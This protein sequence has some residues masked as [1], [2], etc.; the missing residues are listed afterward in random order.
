MRRQGGDD[1]AV[2][3]HGAGCRPGGL[4]GRARATRRP[5][6]GRGPSGAL[7]MPTTTIRSAVDQAGRREWWSPRRACRWR[8]PARRPRPRRRTPRRSATRSVRPLQCG[9]PRAASALAVVGEAVDSVSLVIGGVPSGL[10]V[11]STESRV[12]ERAL[13]SSRP[14]VGCT[15]ISTR[16]SACR[17]CPVGCCRSRRH[18]RDRRIVA[19]L[20]AARRARR[21]GRDD[22]RLRRLGHADLLR[23]RRGGR[24]AHR[25]AH[26][27][28]HLR[29]LAPGQGHRS[30]GR[31][32]RPSSTTA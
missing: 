21:A 8:R 4:A 14:A 9:R 17:R 10:G 16:R 31:A 24:R 3:G 19:A 15:A 5:T 29:R 25:G 28:R 22:G 27:G 18:R 7:P 2:A 6:L 11:G 30:P 20:P 23:R 26:R 32:R 1:L 12:T 13:P